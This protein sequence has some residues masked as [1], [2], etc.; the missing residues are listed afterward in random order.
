VV[1]CVIFVCSVL[2]SSSNFI[3]L[4][5]RYEETMLNCCVD[6]NQVKQTGITF[7]TFACL[8]K[9]QGLNTTPIFGSDSSVEEF[10]NTVKA[11]CSNENPTSFL[12]V[13]YTRKAIGQT[14]TGHFSPIGAYD[15]SSDH[16]LVLDTARFKYG[17]HWV[18]LQ[19]LFD[20]L[21]P[22]DKSTGKSRGY[23][24][25]SYDGVE[26]NDKNGTAISH[27]PLSLL[28]GSKKS[29]DF[30]RREYK[31]YLQEIGVK[32]QII[33][34]SVAKFWT[35]NFTDYYRIWELVEPQLQPIDKR[36]IELVGSL[37]ILVQSLIKMNEDA[38]TIPQKLLSTS[39]EAS[40][41]AP[42]ECCNST[43]RNTSVRT[44]EISP[45]EVLYVV[46]LASL[47]LDVRREIVF[48]NSNEG[49]ED[50]KVD[51]TAREQLLAEAALIS[52]A[53]ESCDADL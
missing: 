34:A 35:T 36:E 1:S 22:E 51:D 25:L 52:Y 30:I 48:K 29:K 5:S 3:S 38:S 11:A 28:F 16:V 50:K 21:V 39:Q 32:E 49:K 44:L 20:A 13:S 15:E 46:Y 53:I 27:L 19:L 18:P 42:G 8:A 33:F 10:R 6:I 47:P 24:T 9:C 31:Q 40:A 17:P 26:G 37:R 12:I 23:M 41:G 43:T 2:P 4:A 7:S 14:G 45:I